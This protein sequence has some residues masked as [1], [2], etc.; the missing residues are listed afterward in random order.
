MSL[1]YLKAQIS[2][3]RQEAAR[4]QTFHSEEAQRISRDPNFTDAYKDELTKTNTET[5]KTKLRDLRE[6]EKA[7]VADK[8]KEIE[9][10]LDAKAGHTGSDIIAFRDAQDRAEKISDADEAERI[11][12]RA[13]RN[14]DDTLA[15]A[16]FRRALEARW[17]KAVNLFA[18]EKPD[19]TEA[20][21]DL[22]NIR[23]E[24]TNNFER[25]MHYAYFG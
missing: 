10:A 6:K 25:A 15:Y 8:A 11:I 13:L 21:K 20:A 22:V 9:K 23:E 16:V 5:A 14:N 12:A 17:A 4:A 1:D 24:Q 19:A 18:D 3:V 7:L 2:T